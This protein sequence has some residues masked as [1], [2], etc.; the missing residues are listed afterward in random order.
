MSQ[1]ACGCGHGAVPVAIGS[2]RITAE[3]T[4]EDAKKRPGALD[5]LQRF[6][7]NHCCGAHLTLRESAASAGVRV[8]DVLEALASA[9]A[10]A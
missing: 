10:R 5:V 9:G 4:V 2:P 3:T 6:G 8:E 7:L 1:C